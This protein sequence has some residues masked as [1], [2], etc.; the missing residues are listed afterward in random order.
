MTLDPSGD[1]DHKTMFNCPVCNANDYLKYY[2][3]SWKQPRI[4]VS[5]WVC[6]SCGSTGQR[7]YHLELDRSVL[8]KVKSNM[9]GP[10][11]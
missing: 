4:V 1:P 3:Y 10:D 8:T 11:R 6:L 2:A 7:E 5:A 9:T